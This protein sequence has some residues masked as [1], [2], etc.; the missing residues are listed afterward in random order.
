MDPENIRRCREELSSRYREF[1]AASSIQ[2]RADMA[3]VVDN[4]DHIRAAMDNMNRR[5]SDPNMPQRPKDSSPLA[6][7]PDRNRPTSAPPTQWSPPP[8]PGAYD[9]PNDPFSHM[10]HPNFPFNTPQRQP[11]PVFNVTA[12][13]NFNAPNS[14]NYNSGNVNNH[15]SV[16]HDDYSNNVYNYDYD[17]GKMGQKMAKMERKMAEK[18]GSPRPRQQDS[19]NERD[20]DDRRRRGR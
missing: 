6:P 3:A 19:Y 18:F 2:L 5:A 14:M 11:P 10:R 8:T 15:F 16:G 20:W 1:A 9:D 13:T 7:P 12:S 4:T 17:G